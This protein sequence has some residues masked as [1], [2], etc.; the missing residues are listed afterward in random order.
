MNA[1]GENINIITEE[2]SVQKQKNINPYNPSIDW[3]SYM[4]RLE[5]KIQTNWNPPE[6]YAS[7][8]VI[9]IINIAKDG[10]LLDAKI[11]VSSGNNEVDKLA[12][13]TIKNNAPYEPLPKEFKG[14][15]IPIEFTF[16]YNV[17]NNITNNNQNISKT[18]FCKFMQK[19]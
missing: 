10:T 6:I 9:T 7:K 5:T 2:S 16:K 13:E 18:K 15:F 4:Q 3:Q 12:I 11:G 14:E 1:Y 17:R 8:R 19:Y